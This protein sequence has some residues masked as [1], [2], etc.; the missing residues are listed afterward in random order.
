MRLSTFVLRTTFDFALVPALALCAVKYR[1]IL[2]GKRQATSPAEAEKKKP[3]SKTT[4]TEG[5]ISYRDAASRGYMP[6]T[7]LIDEW[8]GADSEGDSWQLSSL[9]LSR[10]RRNWS[11]GHT[12]GGTP[13]GT[14]P[15]A[16]WQGAA[17][18][19]PAFL[20]KHTIPSFSVKNEGAFREELEVEIQTINEQPFRGS[21][22]RQEAKHLIFKE[23]LGCPFSNFRGVRTGY[24]NCPT[25]TFMLKRAINI[26]DLAPFQN[27]TFE[28]KYRKTDGTDVVDTF[29]GKLKGVVKRVLPIVNPA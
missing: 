24:K 21:I 16:R 12:P 9:G 1:M 3:D 20:H 8:D 6:P 15:S 25:A 29:R 22:T 13:E 2:T 11:T 26:D 19:N 23:A 5:S 10:R 18:P 17:G 7:E 27:F 28:R 14:P 4:P